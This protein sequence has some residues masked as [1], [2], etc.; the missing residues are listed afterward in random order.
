[1]LKKL[2]MSAILAVT[3]VISVVAQNT[4]LK[5][6][7]APD[8]NHWYALRQR[9]VAADARRP[10]MAPQR[11]EKIDFTRWRSGRATLRPLRA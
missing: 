6:A 10:Q 1:M 9:L 11:I 2:I 4:T 3:P 7:Q 8:S 5:R